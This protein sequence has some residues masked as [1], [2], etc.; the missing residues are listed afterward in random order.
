MYEV[1]TLSA[2]STALI[3]L[4]SYVLLHIWNEIE[5]H[6]SSYFVYVSLFIYMWGLF[7]IKDIEKYFEIKRISTKQ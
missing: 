2:Q 3:R 6:F 7:F 5:R 4:T 1:P